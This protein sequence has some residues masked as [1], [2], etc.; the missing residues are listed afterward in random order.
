MSLLLPEMRDHEM[1]F[2]SLLVYSDEGPEAMA[3]FAVY[4]H[5]RLRE[6]VRGGVTHGRLDRS[7]VCLLLSH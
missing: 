6:W 4:G 3:R 7:P 5:A 2:A 1:R